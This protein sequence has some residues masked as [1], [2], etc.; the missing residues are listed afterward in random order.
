VDS[1]RLSA[2]LSQIQAAEQQLRDIQGQLGQALRSD[3]FLTSIQQRSSIP[4]GSFDFDLPQLHCWLQ[5]P[6]AARAQALKAWKNTVAAV[7]QAVDLSVSL[8]RSSTTPVT[9]T[10]HN[11]LFQHTLDKQLSVQLL[12]VSLP[13]QARLY[14]EISGSKHRFSIRFMSTANDGQHPKSITHDVDFELTTCVI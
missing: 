6:H 13:K 10:A 11:G 12:R 2:V 7:Q 5:Q 8:I 1:S 3:D 14:A 9:E 4:G